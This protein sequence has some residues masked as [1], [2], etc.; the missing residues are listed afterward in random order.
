M[1]EMR[2]RSV[3]ADIESQTSRPT[4]RYEVNIGELIVVAIVV[5]IVAVLVW[6]MM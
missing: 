1:D 5:L 4:P 2:R 6:L 3:A